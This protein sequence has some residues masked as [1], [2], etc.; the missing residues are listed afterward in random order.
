[1]VFALE[2]WVTS[3]VMHRYLLKKTL[4][5]LKRSS[6]QKNI[7]TNLTIEYLISI[8]PKDWMCP[9]LNIKMSWGGNIDDSP[10]L[11]KIDPKKGYTIGNVIFMSMK[12]NKIKSFF[13]LNQMSQ[14]IE[15]A[16]KV[17]DWM[18]KKL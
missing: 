17:F 4:G 2:R 8:F 10:S 7:K 11:D 5:S 6:K 15:D 18:K 12:A 3:E 9:V 14:H 16:H 1:M 13:D